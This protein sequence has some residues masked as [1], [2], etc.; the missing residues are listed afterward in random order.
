MQGRLRSVWMLPTSGAC[1]LVAHALVYR[2]FLP[3]GAV[4]EYL[5]WYEPSLALLAVASIVGLVA[6]FKPG[7]AWSHVAGGGVLLFFLQESLERSLA[8]GGVQIASLSAGTWLAVLT[9]VASF[10]WLISLVA[11][12]GAAL[13]RL[14]RRVRAPRE[15]RPFAARPK[16]F[17]PPRRR[18]PL[19]ERRGLRAPPLLLA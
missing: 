18:H 4:H 7:I 17:V 11:R 3:G 5:A 8:D 19:A 2:S 1:A 13:V 10:A 16:L 15:R 6:T 12:S 14:V 9:A